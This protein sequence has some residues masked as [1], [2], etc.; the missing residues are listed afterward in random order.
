M[1]TERNKIVNSNRTLNIFW[2]SEKEVPRL[3]KLAV[4]SWIL[5]NHQVNVWTLGK[6]YDFGVEVSTIDFTKFCDDIPYDMMYCQTKPFSDERYIAGFVDWCRFKIIDILGSGVIMDTDIILFKPF[7]TTKTT[8]VCEESFRGS[9]VLYG[10]YPCAGIFTDFDGISKEL[11]PKAK[12]LLKD[13]IKHGTIMNLLYQHCVDN[14]RGDFQRHYEKTFKPYV[15][16]IEHNQF[17]E[18]GYDELSV[19]YDK[20]NTSVLRRL[21]DVNGIHCWMSILD[22]SKAFKEGTL[23]HLLEVLIMKHNA[24]PLYQLLKISKTT[25]T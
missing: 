14:Y 3:V 13:G 2:H 24:I 18:L 11:E 20:V 15:D 4:K 6:E 19:F 17:F 21:K 16:I 7:I 25:L 12:A 1:I 10:L 23:L 9:N 8:F 5:Q 22:E